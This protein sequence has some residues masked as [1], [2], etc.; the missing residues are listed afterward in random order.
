MKTA[1]DKDGYLLGL[2]HLSVLDGGAY[3]SFGVITAY[4]N[5]SLLTGP[6]RLPA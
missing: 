5:G 6:Y 2:E 4:Y 3:S 1:V